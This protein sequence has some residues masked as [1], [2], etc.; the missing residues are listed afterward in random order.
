MSRGF[1]NGLLILLTSKG[2]FRIDRHP[3]QKQAKGFVPRLERQIQK[4]KA[5][6]PTPR[7]DNLQNPAGSKTTAEWIAD[8]PKASGGH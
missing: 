1:F 8:Q 7:Q 2:E 4:V 5:G 3:V 6:E